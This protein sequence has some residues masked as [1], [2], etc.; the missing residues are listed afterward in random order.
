[1][2]NPVTLPVVSAGPVAAKERIQ[3]IDV[4]RGVALLGIL[5]MNIQDFSMIGQAYLNPTARLPRCSV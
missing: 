2:T 1:V 3:S 4:M 5:A